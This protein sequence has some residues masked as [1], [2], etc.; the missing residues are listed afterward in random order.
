VVLDTVLYRREH[1]HFRPL[2]DPTPD[3]RLRLSGLPNL[4]LIGVV[5]AAILLSASWK[6]GVAFTIAGTPIE[7]QNVLRDI[8]MVLATGA[9]LAITAPED[10][11]GNGFSWG[12]IQEVAKLFAG[13]FICIVPVLAMLRAGSN[14][15]FASL[16]ALVTNPDG[17]ANNAAYFWLT[18]ILSSFLDNAPTYL[19]FFE[20]AGGDPARLMTT[21]ALT[22]AAIS[23][24]AVF[25]GANTYIGNARTSWSTP[26]PSPAA[27]RCPGSS[28]TCC[29]RARCCCPSS[30]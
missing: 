14:G 24:G 27:S 2:A 22:L 19:V 15:A 21:G 7:L 17:S 25:M 18:G 30:R 26:S 29:G 9:S 8:V 13:I 11:E 28:A 3:Q 20:T 12:P 1:E 4:A 6:P 23:C 16:V 5:I 10:R